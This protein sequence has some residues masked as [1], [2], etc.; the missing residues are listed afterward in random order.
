MKLTVF[1]QSNPWQPSATDPRM[2]FD[3]NND[4][5][6]FTTN[7]DQAVDIQLLEVDR[8]LSFPPEVR[9]NAKLGIKLSI[10]HN[11]EYQVE[12]TVH[13]TPKDCIIIT[14]AVSKYNHPNL[15]HNDFLF[16]R[17]K[18]YYLGFNFG[19]ETRRWYF[20]NQQAFVVPKIVGA[21][22]KT[23]IY[24]APNKTYLNDPWRVIKFRPQL[25]QLL[26]DCFGDL[27]YIGENDLIK[28]LFLIP[29]VQ[30]P[31]CQDLSQ[32]V[33]SAR[34][35]K[36]Q[37]G[38]CPPH[39]EYYKNT[40][41]SIYGETIEYGTSIAVTEKTY[42]PLIKGHFILPFSCAGFVSYLNTL[43][44]QFPTFI[45]Y[46]YDNISND[47]K[48]FASYTDEVRR[49]LSLQLDTWREH[50]NNNLDIIQHN[51]SIFFDRDYDRVDFS[52]IL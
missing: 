23:K 33:L 6:E 43:G 30:M 31:D 48:R 16:N 10:F 40:F 4:V 17:T 19:P 36:Y 51:Q 26:L 50:W 28:N 38:Y 44:F 39:N 3:L 45:N 9:A 35:Q 47:G 52:K 7:L 27:G 1:Y 42:D 25:V 29:H 34:N 5:C 18:A 8:P 46:D 21:D 24:V 22:Y 15:I 41:I 37:F 20:Y 14:N 32:V 11:C 12:G 2:F 49:L 13:D